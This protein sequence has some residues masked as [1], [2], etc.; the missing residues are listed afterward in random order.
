MKQL[1][2]FDIF[3]FLCSL[4]VDASVKLSFSGLLVELIVFATFSWKL[5]IITPEDQNLVGLTK[6]LGETRTAK[7]GRRNSEIAD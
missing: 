6:R 5:K 1:L 2:L 4:P 7:D 3:T